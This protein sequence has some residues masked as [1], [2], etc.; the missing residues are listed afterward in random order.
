MQN[1]QQPFIKQVPIHL[2]QRLKKLAALNGKVQF[3]KQV[4]V[5]P[6][7]KLKIKK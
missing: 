6:W 5:H 1:W 3:V 7:D 4:P 2:R